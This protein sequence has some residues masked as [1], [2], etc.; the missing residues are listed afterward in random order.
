MIEICYNKKCEDYCNDD[1]GLVVKNHCN[2]WRVVSLCE[3]FKME[4]IFPVPEDFYE[5]FVME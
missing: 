4:K 5:L 1:E 3:K 2:K